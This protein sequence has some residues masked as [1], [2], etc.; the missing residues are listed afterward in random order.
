MYDDGYSTNCH[1]RA[2]KDTIA[3]E[4]TTSSPYTSDI[5]GN[6]GVS[7]LTELSRGGTIHDLMKIS[8][9]NGEKM[10]AQ[11]RLRVGYHVAAGLAALH[12][13]DGAP[14]IAHN[15]I[16]CHQYI[17]ID[18]VYK[19]NDFH[20]ASVL[21]LKEDGS[22]CKQFPFRQNVKVGSETLYRTL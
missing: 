15:D 7:Q 12:S 11:D 3:M 4:R 16:C 22:P 2:W 9:R 10:T 1:H 18:G 21:T 5:Y 19:L 13:F 6:C 17:L 20:Q 8:R 14:S